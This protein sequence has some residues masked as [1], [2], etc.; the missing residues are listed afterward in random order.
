[1]QVPYEADG[2]IKEE[3]EADDKK[4][5]K[6]NYN[7]NKM[8]KKEKMTPKRESSLPTKNKRVPPSTPLSTTLFLMA[9]RRSKF[10][11]TTMKLLSR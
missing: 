10:L 7:N 1:M 4:R 2:E 9:N 11:F 3:A 5:K 6:N 8:T